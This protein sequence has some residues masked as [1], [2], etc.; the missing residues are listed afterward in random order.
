MR[1]LLPKRAGRGGPPARA[2]NG[3]VRTQLRLLRYVLPH[4]RELRVILITMAL[5]VGVDVLQPWP[6][7]IL[8]DNVLGHQRAPEWLDRMVAALPGPDGASGL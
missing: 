2:V 6:M 4:W 3:R 8:V 5:A 1:K 7:K